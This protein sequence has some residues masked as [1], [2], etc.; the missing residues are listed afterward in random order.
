MQRLVRLSILMMVFVTPAVAQ[1]STTNTT[2]T[3][4]TQTT[5]T[6]QT[7]TKVTAT[8]PSKTEI[9]GGF[10]LNRYYEITGT[11]TSMPGWY[12]DVEHNIIQRWLGAE[13]QGVGGYT[14]QG[15]LGN[16]SVYTLMAG[17]A[18]YPFGH[19]RITPFA[20]VLIGEGYYRNAIAPSTGFPAQTITHTSLAWA[21][22][23][24]L[25]YRVTRK[26]S[27]RLAQFD[28]TELKF[29]PGTV[30]ENDMRI[31]GGIVYHFG[32]K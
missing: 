13:I 17:P 18:F 8:S 25:D 31:S 10:T 12:G 16:L 7:T 21:G 2:Q 19:R 28:Y 30:H 1:D 4:T 6:T 23:G 26:L 3:T 15:A 14:N 22:G 11:T 5:S 29:M 32:G 20:H 9:S 27:I 24:G